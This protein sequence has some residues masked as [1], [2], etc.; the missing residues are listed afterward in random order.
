MNKTCIRNLK[1]YAFVGTAFLI[2][3]QNLSTYYENIDKTAVFNE[4]EML[5]S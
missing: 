2:S 5:Q 3:F 1:I 4:L